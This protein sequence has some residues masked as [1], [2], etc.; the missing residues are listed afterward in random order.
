[1]NKIEQEKMFEFYN[2]MNKK[3]QLSYW[4]YKNWKKVWKN[5][6]SNSSS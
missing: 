5:Y 4:F 6:K 2:K 1:M 3:T